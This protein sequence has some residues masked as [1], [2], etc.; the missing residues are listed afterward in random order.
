MSISVPPGQPSITQTLSSSFRDA[1]ALTKTN[2][3]VVVIALI[4]GVIAAIGVIVSGWKPNSSAF[5]VAL[6]AWIAPAYFALIVVSYYA[7]AAAVRTINPEYRMTAGHFFGFLGYALLA[8]LL[9]TIAGFFLIIPAYWV[10]VKIMLTPYT[11]IV[12]NG[13]PDSLKR[14]WRM[15]TGYYWQT[16]GMMLLSGICFGV[17]AYAAFLICGFAAYAAPASAIVFAPLALAVFMW[18]THVHALVYVRWTNGL[19]PRANAP[20]AVLVPA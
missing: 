8:G 14:T 5:P 18:L 11:Y 3:A 15:T 4:M 16:V 7:I 9:T 12:T 19:L 20:E 17:I 6:E 10:G 1:I 2:T 13:E